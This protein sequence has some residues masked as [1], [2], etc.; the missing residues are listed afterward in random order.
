MTIFQKKRGFAINS[1]RWYFSLPNKFPPSSGL[2]WHKKNISGEAPGDTLIISSNIKFIIW[3]IILL[4]QRTVVNHKYTVFWTV[5]L[6]VLGPSIRF[7]FLWSPSV[8]N[9]ISYDMEFH[10]IPY[11]DMSTFWILVASYGISHII[12]ESH[13]NGI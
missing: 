10:G 1:F 8:R 9:D 11:Y 6:T 7:L 3:N 12:F 2:A 5:W 4:Y 13:K